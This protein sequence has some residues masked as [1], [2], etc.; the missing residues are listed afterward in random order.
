[1][2]DVSCSS[3]TT[4]TCTAINTQPT[5]TAILKLLATYQCPSCNRKI[6]GKWSNETLEI[7]LLQSL[8]VC[9]MYIRGGAQY[10]PDW[11]HHLY[12]SSGS[13][14]HRSQQAKLRSFAAIGWKR[15]TT[16][17]RTL[18]R[19][20]LTASPWQRPPSQSSPSC[21]WRNKKWLSSPTYRTPLIWHPVTSSHFQNCNW[22]WK[23]AGLNHWGDP[24]RIAECWTLRQKRTSRNRSKNG[25]D[26]GTGVYMREGTTSRVKAA[27]RPYGEFY[28]FYSVSP[29]HF[30]YTLVT[31]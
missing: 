2:E 29:E 22:S 7:L 31:Y 1:M 3:S 14:K 23:D 19:T 25:G 16:S 20:D 26:G 27:D 6:R 9:P 24:G 12:N 8:T 11:C 5:A 13:A 28:Y 4:S 10:I 15:A 17:P 21:F 18:P 30:G